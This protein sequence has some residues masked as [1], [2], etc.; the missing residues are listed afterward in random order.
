MRAFTGHALGTV[1]DFALEPKSRPCPGPGQLRIRVEAVGLGFVDA[2]VMRGLY[3]AKPTLPFVPGGEIVGLVEDAGD[4]VG[5]FARG[6]RIAAWQF[7]GGLADQAVVNHEDAVAVPEGVEPTAAAAILLDYLTAYYGLFDRGRLKPGE[8]VLVT[9]ASG[10]VGSAAVQL[11]AATGCRVAALASGAKKLGYA[12]ARGAAVALDYRDPEW[13]T[14]LKGSFPDGI[15]M[16]FDPVGGSVFEPAFRSLAKR[17]RH[18]V[19]GF[20][21]G[22][23]IPSLPANLVLL[24][25]AELVGVDARFLWHTDKPRVRAILATLLDLLH[26][27]RI[28]PCIAEIVPLDEAERAFVTLA[29]VDRLGKVVVQP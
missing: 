7:G 27:G 14:Q 15:R 17:G 25:S 13:R 18:L 3:Q 6:Q 9:G 11:A 29:N 24:K 26:A 20:A 22:T 16:V 2:L 12:R 8:A 19:V 1:E 23:G 4:K 21:A 10:G 5:G 28:E